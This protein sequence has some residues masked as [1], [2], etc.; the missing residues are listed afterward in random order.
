MRN[1]FEFFKTKHLDLQILDRKEFLVNQFSHNRKNRILD[2]N[3]VAVVKFEVF[4]LAYPIL[5]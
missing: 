1:L 3:V 4:Y 2:L 5:A